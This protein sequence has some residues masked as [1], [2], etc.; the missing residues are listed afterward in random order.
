MRR[1]WRDHRELELRLGSS[2]SVHCLSREGCRLTDYPKRP[3][4]PNQ[5]AKSI[6]DIATGRS[7]TATL[8]PKSRARTRPRYNGAVQADLRVARQRRKR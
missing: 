2:I 4:D 3:W 6:I 8:R 7:L 1:V 5:F